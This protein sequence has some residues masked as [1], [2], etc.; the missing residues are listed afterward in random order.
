MP[1]FACSPLPAMSFFVTRYLWVPL[2]P[3]TPMTSF[4]NGPLTISHWFGRLNRHAGIGD[5]LDIPLGSAFRKSIFLAVLFEKDFLEGALRAELAIV[6]FVERFSSMF[7]AGA[8][9][10]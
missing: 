4:L 7:K 8:I 1:L 2:S 5:P 9:L 3:S 6:P 10:S